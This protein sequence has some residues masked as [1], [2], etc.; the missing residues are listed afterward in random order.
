MNNKIISLNLILSFFGIYLSFFYF[1]TNQY[2]YASYH[3]FDIF[4][5]TLIISTIFGFP[6]IF[7]IYFLNYGKKNILNKIA[8]SFSQGIIVYIVFHYVIKFSD[9]NYFHIYKSFIDSNNFFIKSIFYFFPFMLT[10]IVSFLLNSKQIYKINKFIL[11]LLIILNLS[12]IYRTTQIYM[13]NE[14]KIFKLSD[15]KDLK[16]NTN[17]NQII[18]KKVFILI[19]DEF[20]Q[21]IFE[22]NFQK[23]DH[24]NEF[25]NSSYVNKNFYSPAKFTIDS[26]PAILTGNSTKQTLFKKGQLYIKD[27]NDKL[28]HFS[29]DNS[30]FNIK[31]VSSSIYATYHP[32]CRILK[33]VNC[34]DKFNFKKNE[35]DLIDGINN[36]LNV[37]YLDRLIDKMIRF[38]KDNLNTI[39]KGNEFSKD[40]EF[41]KFMIQNSLS[42]LKSDTNIIFIHYPFPHPPFKK[43]VVKIKKEYQDLSDYEKNLFLID[44]T[45]LKI[46]QYI[47]KQKDSLLIV[48]SD[49]WHKDISENKSLPMVFFSKIIGDNKYYEE[50][51][52]KNAS[53]IKQL[54]IDFFEGNIT[55]NKDINNFFKT[56]KNHKTYVR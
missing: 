37:I 24:I 43:G 2:F 21:S 16:V 31:N 8:T 38:D 19:F 55:S 23:F 28:I 25:Y 44:D 36:F 29:H 48:S 17:K 30:F 34:Y 20:D 53:N 51:N 54:I 18:K 9:I 1:G 35:I 33:V 22:K 40:T 42:F 49:H 52:E 26:I 32:Y 45:F 6:I 10:F 47:N 46:K 41:S 50:N 4:K 11:I 3:L 5:S 15:F 39:E 14:N 27:L 13:F 56:K 12:S 7:S